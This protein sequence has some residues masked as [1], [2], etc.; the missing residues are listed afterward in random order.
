MNNRRA[1]KSLSHGAARF[2][3]SLQRYPS[4]PT[5]QVASQLSEQGLP[6]CD[7]WLEFHERYAGYESNIGQDGMVWGLMHKTNR[8]SNHAHKGV[9]AEKNDANDQWL[10]RCADMD[11]HYTI[12][13]NEQGYLNFEDTRYSSF[14]MFI[15]RSAHFVDFNGKGQ[16][17]E[18][19]DTRN[20]MALEIIA[21]TKRN[22]ALSDQFLELWESDVA[23]GTRIPGSDTW[24]DIRLVVP[25]KSG[26]TQFVYAPYTPPI[27]K[28]AS[29]K[30]TLSRLFSKG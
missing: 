25:G 2:L 16:V 11:P 29:V 10:V 28:S 22:D 5:E 3:D 4:V 14:D 7:A 26:K 13:L 12:E 24:E 27:P 18:Y 8:Y 15:E 23:M 9:L 20:Q 1:L 17:T 21:T 19:I 30:T 6:T